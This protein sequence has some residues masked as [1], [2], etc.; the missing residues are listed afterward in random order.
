[1]KIEKNKYIL[2]TRVGRGAKGEGKVACWG[3]G[4][5]DVFVHE[6]IEVPDIRVVVGK[7]VKL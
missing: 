5:D 6:E 3:G 2:A 4:N 7:A 1:M